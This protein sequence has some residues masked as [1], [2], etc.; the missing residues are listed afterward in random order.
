V[1]TCASFC[2]SFD[3]GSDT[4]ARSGGQIPTLDREKHLWLSG[5]RL[6]AGLDEVGRGAWAGP[7]FAAAVILPDDLRSLEKQLGE[8]RDSKQLSPKKRSRLVASIY[9]AALTV[10][11]GQSSHDDVDR[12][13]LVAATRLAMQAARMRYAKS[14]RPGRSQLE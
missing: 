9:G 14:S 1:V 3:R 7:V 11:V 4:M 5:Y 8:V 10:G 6:V 2:A 12:L 13:G